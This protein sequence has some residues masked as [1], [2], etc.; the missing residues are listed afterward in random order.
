MDP[1]RWRYVTKLW[2][3]ALLRRDRVD[4]D[5]DE[6]LRSHIEEHTARLIENGMSPAEAR[7][8]ARRELGRVDLV[9]EHCRDARRTHVIDAGVQDVRYALRML[10]QHRGFTLVAV[11]T[12]ALGIGANSAIFSLIEGILLVPLPYAQPERLVSVSGT[13]PKGAFAVMRNEIQSMDVAAYA[14]GHQYNLTGRGE[15]VRLDVTPVSAEL[16][17]I[18]G[19][20]A[21]LGRTF[22][23]GEDA[24]GADGFAILSYTTWERRFGRDADIIGRPI[25]LD[26]AL[27]Q[28]VGVMPPEFAFPSPK[29]EIWIPLHNDPGCVRCYWGGDFMPVIGRLRQGRTIQQARSEIQAFQARVFGMFP[30]KMPA[31][32]NRDVTVVG[33][34][35]GIVAGIRGRLYMLLGAVALV[36]LIACA[37]VANLMLSR[38]ASREQEIAVRSALGAGRA[39]IVR[40]LLTES[41]VLASIGGVL[42]VLLAVVAL[43]GLKTALPA[44]T[45]RLADVRLDWVVMCFAAALAM[46]TGLLFGV[47]PSRH[48]S[49]ALAESLKSSGRGAPVRV[50]Q[51]LRS[52]LVIGEI[53][54]AVL[55]VIGAGLLIRSLWALSHVNPGFRPEHLMSARISPDRSYCD[56][57][58]R[59]LVFYRTLLSELQAAPGVSGAAIVNT[60]PLDGRVAKQSFE[61]ERYVVPSGK[62]L[63]L[64]WLTVVSPDYFRLLGIPVIAGTG[65]SDAD[66]S[67]NPPVVMVSAATARRFWGDQNA[68]GKRIRFVEETDWRTVVG[69]AGDVR[70]YDLERNVPDWMVG[71]V[72]V[73]WSPRATLEEGRVP[74]DMTVI[75]QSTAEGSRIEARLRRVVSGLSAQT[76]V[77]DVHP[78][79]A[80]IS[81][82]VSTPASTTALFSVFAAVALLLGIVGVYGVVSFLVSKRTREIGIRMALGASRRQVLWLVLSEGAWFSVLGIG[83]GLG[84]AVVLTRVLSSELHGVSS[85][86]PVTFSSVALLMALITLAACSVPTRRAL[87]V[88]PLIALRDE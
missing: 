87:R 51:R 65:F 25:E 44:D 85:L 31:D 88:D 83:I 47:A 52:G 7:M 11:L 10:R 66:S 22:A 32:W 3:R 18:L 75:L 26:G 64:M 72:Y 40:Q 70:A 63:P 55:L 13:Y 29:T 9:A 34:H 73:P 48:I 84:A 42:G 38:A 23:P 2:L 56:D 61:I 30:W 19:A 69:I 20:R 6:E 71:T 24:P 50:S 86:D 14:E 58:A 36:L 43:A 82:A 62:T 46:L 5:L 78:M 16:M 79:R 15:A 4:D 67:G 57:T 77:A 27:R 59:C 28:V 41:I 39:R 76:A 37:N 33:L 49:R 53:A 60:P 35:D 81:A 12:L 17:S 45:P 1:G 80:S 54:F 21:A 74:A 68:I 8:R